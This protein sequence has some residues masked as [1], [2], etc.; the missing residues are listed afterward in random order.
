MPDAVYKNPIFIVFIMYQRFVFISPRNN[1]CQMEWIYLCSN[2][3]LEALEVVSVLLGGSQTLS[4]ERTCSPYI[5]GQW[6]PCAVARLR[7]MYCRCRIYTVADNRS[8]TT[9][10]LALDFDLVFLGIEMFKEDQTALLILVFPVKCNSG[11]AFLRSLHCA[12]LFLLEM[13]E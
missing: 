11:A 3:Y 7:D 6:P 10:S 9:C 4:L 13:Y 8:R 5:T 1:T 12:V 2:L